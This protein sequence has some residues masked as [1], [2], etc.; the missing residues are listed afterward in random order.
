MKNAE[1][2]RAL[3]K[4]KLRAL[5]REHSTAEI[6]EQ[7]GVSAE[8]VRRVLIQ[9]GIPRRN[10]GGRRTFNPSK[11][12]LQRLYQ[13]LS[14]KQIAR[15]FDV[16][17]TVVWKRL[18]EYGIKLRDFE[19]GGHRKKPGRTF[20]DQHRKNISK[21]LRNTYRDDPTKHPCWKGGATE[22]NLRL[23]RSGAYKQ[24]RIEAKALHKNR[25]QECGVENKSV[26]E[27]CGTK[28]TLHLHHIRSFAKYPE[29]RF[30][31][32]NSEL[33]CPKC[34]YARHYGKTA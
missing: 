24:W 3:G 11:Q 32:A 8:L 29:S 13:K 4:R 21:A 16:G 27:C 28:V 10:R 20:S 15:R 6:A 23:R 12:V 1:K 22:R 34:H 5:Y 7:H 2:F 25:C 19:D 33:L 9:A 31:P 30:D 17:E 14:M 26:C 18:K